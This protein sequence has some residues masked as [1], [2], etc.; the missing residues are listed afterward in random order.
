MNDIE[1]LYPSKYLKPADLAGGEVTVTIVNV[2]VEEIGQPKERRAILSLKEYDKRLVLNKINTNAVAKLHG[3]S[4]TNWPGKQLGLYPTTTSYGGQMVDCIGV[5]A[6]RGGSSAPP[7][8]A[9][10]P[11]P[12]RTQ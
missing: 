10:P 7:A 2:M 4:F 6:P 3:N 8:A 9:P 5:K 12:G 1:K 11:P